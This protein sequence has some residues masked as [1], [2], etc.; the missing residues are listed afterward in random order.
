[1]S[2]TFAKIETNMMTFIVTSSPNPNNI[3]YYKDLFFKHNVTLIVRLCGNI[4]DAKEFINSGFDFVDLTIDDGSIPDEPM[5]KKWM[6][7]AKNHKIIAV[8]CVAGLGRAPMF[9]CLC[10]MKFNKFE[11][12]DAI[13]TIRKHIP[14]SLNTR[15]LNFLNNYKFKNEICI[16]C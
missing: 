1:M 13:T 10:L 8:H 12:I 6:D 16:I 3:K 9:V 7:V 15:Q 2:D 11:G 5:I 4:Y 14:K